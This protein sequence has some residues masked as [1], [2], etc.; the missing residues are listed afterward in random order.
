MIYSYQMPAFI[1][2][3]QKVGFA[4]DDPTGENSA[5]AVA[6]FS[7]HQVG[8]FV[9]LIAVAVGLVVLTIAG[10]FSGRRAKIGMVLL[11]GFPVL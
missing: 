4:N 9:V 11:G 10:C 8:W 2:Y 7:L 6:A 5:T 1:H 3:L